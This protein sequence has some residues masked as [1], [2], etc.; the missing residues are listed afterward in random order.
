M[1]FFMPIAL[2][3]YHDDSRKPVEL[4]AETEFTKDRSSAALPFISLHRTGDPP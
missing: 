4:T 1:I 2:H 3:H